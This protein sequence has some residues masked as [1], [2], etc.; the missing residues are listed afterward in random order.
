MTPDALA[1][2][3]SRRFGPQ[4]Q[5]ALARHLG[6]TSRTVRRWVS[7]DTPIPPWVARVSFEPDKAPPGQKPSQK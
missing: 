2:R 3:A 7:G 5:S 6:I 4:W 1:K